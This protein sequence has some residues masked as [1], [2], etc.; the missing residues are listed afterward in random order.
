[1][2]SCTQAYHQCRVVTL[3]LHTS[4]ALVWTNWKPAFEPCAFEKCSARRI[5]EP[6]TAPGTEQCYVALQQHAKVQIKQAASWRRRDTKSSSSATPRRDE[7]EGEGGG[8]GV[9]EGLVQ[10]I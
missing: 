10:G 7:R 1:M 8:V 4:I 6:L 3:Q 5:P 9:L 2:V